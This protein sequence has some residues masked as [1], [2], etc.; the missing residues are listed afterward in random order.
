MHSMTRARRAIALRPSRGFTLIEMLVSLT[1]TLLMMGATVALFGV[2]ADSVSG[3]RAALEMSDRL[4]GCRNRIQLDLQGATAT[5][6]PPLRPE[7]DEGYMEIGEGVNND[8]N[9][10]GMAGAGS[11]LFGDV[12]DYIAFTTRSRGEPFVGKYNNTSTIESQ[13]AEVVYFLARTG[14]E[15]IMDA[16]TATPTRLYTLY[17]RVMLV[18][19]NSGL[20]LP[21]TLPTFYDTNDISVH[22]EGAGPVIVAN[23]LGDLTKPE[24]R[25]NHPASGV[26]STFPFRFNTAQTGFIGARLGDD[27]LMT[28]VLGFDVQVWDPGAPVYLTAATPAVSVEPRDRGYT[29]PGSPTIFGAYVDLGYAQSYFATGTNPVPLFNGLPNAKCGTQVRPFCYDTWSLHYENDGIK[30]MGAFADQGTNGLD[31]DGLN[32][33]DDIGEYD[34][35]PPYSAPLRGVR[36]VVRV[37]EPSSQQIREVTIIQDFMPE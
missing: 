19:P 15:P 4:R 13:V 22:L 34:T 36:V 5:M 17:R 11:T 37:Y 32:G 26:G 23:T 16:T 24:N 25:F 12:D 27:V 20:A 8:A 14:T 21:G 3:S 9:Y 33:V 18:I 2:I 30:Q 29:L 28:N 6:N 31:D 1:I 35:L 10:G 7:N